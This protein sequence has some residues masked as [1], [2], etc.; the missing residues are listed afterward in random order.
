MQFISCNPF[1]NELLKT[2]NFKT[3]AE[4]ELALVNSS[5][6]FINWR[7]TTLNHKIQC[8]EN[9]AN[10]IAER[11]KDL[12]KLSAIEMGKPIT[13]A[14]DEVKKCAFVCRYYAENIEKYL[15]LHKFKLEGFNAEVVFE[16]LGAILGIMPWNYPYWQVFR[17]AIPALLSG[18]IVLLKHAPN[19]PQC[20]LAIE[21]LFTD[22][23]FSNGVFQNLFI[24]HQQ[25]EQV[26]KDK[27]IAAV[28]FTGS[29]KAGAIIGAL[30][31]GA[32]KKSVLEL[33]GSDPFI[34]L[35]NANIEK[36]AKFAVKARFNNAGQIC[37][38]A[39]RW[40][41][42]EKVAEEFLNHAINFISE[43]KIGNPIEA[44]V[45][46]GP[47]ARTDLKENL[48]RQVKKS[49][50]MGAKVLH[51]NFGDSKHGSNFFNPIILGN[52]TKEMPAGCEEL[53][54]PVA[55]LYTFKTEQE[56][57]DLANDTEY[58]LGAAIWT[59]N[60]ENA[61][62]LASKIETGTVA[63]NGT[64]SSHPALPFGGVKQ[65]GYGREL[66]LWGLQEFVNVKTITIR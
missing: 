32:L 40:I 64:V 45:N 34:V 5:N 37:I 10:L 51:G 25:T 18:N 62:E 6:A 38:A 42:H 13:Q 36:A 57:I 33:G 30:A 14:E 49:I 63:I 50:E 41:V 39:K 56:A 29:A 20:A 16:P 22:A 1:N 21:K 47:L 46:M 58:G 2:F 61:K 27:R 48:V 3:S 66:G 8:V 55:T 54:G 59:S 9:L 11:Y 23:G 15:T 60:K 35:K 19:L 28:T 43:W 12:A 53:F 17:Y 31:G 24:S 26:I 44:D 52:V 4:L 65:S 7:N